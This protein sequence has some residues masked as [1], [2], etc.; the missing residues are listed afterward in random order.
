MKT[1]RKIAII[2]IA[3]M[4]DLWENRVLDAALATRGRYRKAGRV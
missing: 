2:R 1:A 4:E 3:D